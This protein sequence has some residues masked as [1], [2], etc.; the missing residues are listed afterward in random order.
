MASSTTPAVEG[1]HPRP[2]FGIT[3]RLIPST[4]TVSAVWSHGSH[5]LRRCVPRRLLGVLKGTRS[6]N[7]RSPLPGTC[8]STARGPDHRR[9]IIAKTTRRV[10][11]SLNTL[12]RRVDA[13]GFRSSLKVA[14]IEI[15]VGGPGR[16]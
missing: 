7:A 14:S 15:G 3:I 4:V 13:R 12:P 8:D 2:A 9:L 5:R 6:T 16:R 10:N 11:D 1:R